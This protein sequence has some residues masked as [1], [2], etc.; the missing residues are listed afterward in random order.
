MKRSSRS[1]RSDASARTPHASEATEYTAANDTALGVARAR[2]SG[3]I[4]VP[5]GATNRR[6]SRK[7]EVG[8]AGEKGGYLGRATKQTLLIHESDIAVIVPAHNEARHIADLVR[9]TRALGFDVVVVD[10]GS[11]DRTSA[12]AREAGAIVLRHLVNMGKGAAMK[13]GADYAVG[14]GYAAVVFMDGDGQHNVAELPLFLR[15]LRRHEIVFGARHETRS[16]PLVRRLGKEVMSL[17]VKHFYRL[18]LH[19]ILCGYRGIRASAYP[20]V[21]WESHGYN[22]ETEMIA[23]AGKYNLTYR[24]FPIATIYHD[25]YKGMT[26]IDGVRLVWSLIWWRMTH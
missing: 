13:T 6:A 12:L 24:E 10:D 21:R 2:V 25:K 5:R 23:R 7:A 26:V 9:R 1:K 11:R 20:K 8:G 16:M 19:D 18:Q 17:V 22:V 14:R 15:H 3:R 4:P